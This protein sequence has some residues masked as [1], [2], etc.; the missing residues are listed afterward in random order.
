ML[1]CT[2]CYQLQYHIKAQNI[3]QD[4]KN[5]FVYWYLYS[6]SYSTSLEKH[7]MFY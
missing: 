3:K 2:I 5:L 7:T 4:G 1:I 6:T